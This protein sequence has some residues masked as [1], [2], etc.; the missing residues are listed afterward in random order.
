MANELAANM[1]H[2]GDFVD[3]AAPVEVL[4]ARVAVGV[5]PALEACEVPRRMD[6]LPVGREPVERRRWR[7]ASPLPLIAH[8][9]P[10]PGRPGLAGSGGQHLHRGIVRVDRMGAEDVPRDGLRQ[11]GEERRRP[12]DPVGHGGPIEIDPLA[13]VELALTIQG[14][15]VGILRHQYMGEQPRSRSAAL[16]GP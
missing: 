7:R 3:H 2:A 8:V 11:R 13:G 1:G 5:H 12:S 9:G 4:E 10:Q 15:M 14:K 6:T 16:D